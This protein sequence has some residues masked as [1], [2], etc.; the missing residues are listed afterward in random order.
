MLCTMDT[1]DTSGRA[2]TGKDDRVRMSSRAA[3][4]YGQDEEI[5]PFDTTAPE[6]IGDHIFD[7]VD[8]RE[9][10]NTK[11]ASTAARKTS[12]T[13]ASSRNTTNS[14]RRPWQNAYCCINDRHN[15]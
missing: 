8:G 1:A 3:G 11:K 9:A 2:S 15:A 4:P 10:T 7:E 12:G 6:P 13:S 5:P 14:S